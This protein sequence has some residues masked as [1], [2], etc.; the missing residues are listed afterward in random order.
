MALRCIAL[1]GIVLLSK[2]THGNFTEH[3]IFYSFAF[4]KRL[5]KFNTDSDATCLPKVIFDDK[6]SLL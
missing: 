2:V 5:L 4:R 6:R 3:P 1:H